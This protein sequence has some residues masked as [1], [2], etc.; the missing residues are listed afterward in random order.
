LRNSAA[1]TTRRVKWAGIGANY[2]IWGQ[3]LKLTVEISSTKFDK[4]ATVG[5]VRTKDLKTFIAQVQLIF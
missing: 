4:Q 1:S 2:Y 3:D 5:G